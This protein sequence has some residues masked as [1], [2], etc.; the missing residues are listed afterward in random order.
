MVQ[1]AINGRDSASTGISPFFLD[2]GYHVE[3]PQL[4]EEPRDI[5]NTRTM[6][7]RGEDFVAKLKGASE[8][9][10][11]TMA[12]AQQRQ[13]KAANCRRSEAPAYRPG[14]KVWLDLRNVR[15]DRA[16]KKLDARHAK[17]IVLKKISSHTYQLNTPPGID[18]VFHT[19]L[20]RPAA[21][22]PFPSQCQD[23]YQPPAIS[24]EGSDEYHVERITGERMVR[25][26][27]GYR[28]QYRAKWTGYARET[29][30]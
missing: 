21:D 5:P 23:D 19:M 18:N 13:E 26:G 24:E 11:A 25:R 29:L 3:P 8:T 6:R 28:K 22:G 10:Q 9:A 14:D 15:T 12:T 20:L 30:D 2:H 4:E 7:Q 17:F 16:S 27:R 1:L